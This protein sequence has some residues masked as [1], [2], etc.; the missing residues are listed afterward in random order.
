[1][2]ELPEVRWVVNNLQ[3]E[4]V[5]ASIDAAVVTFEKVIL[6]PATLRGITT[7]QYL[8]DSVTKRKVVSIN[9]RGKYVLI[10]LE[11][12]TTILTHFSF[13]GW[14]VPAWAEKAVPRE[15]LHPVDHE[16]HARVV[17]GTD[18]GLLYLT[19][20][21]GLS[22]T[23]IFKGEAEALKSPMLAEMGPDADTDAGQEAL[24]KAIAKTGRRI[25][26]L[27]MD[28]KV[29]CGVGNYLACESLFRAGVHGAEPAKSLPPEKI[30]SLLAAIKECIHLGET[31]ES[32]AWWAVFQRTKCPQEHPV[33][34]EVWGQR[35]HYVCYAHQP[36][37]VNWKKN[38]LTL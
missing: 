25:R 36:P 7:E 34:R 10:N 18:K 33:T 31:E 35:G 4:L 16:R 30:T 32:K 6:K 9:R 19:D 29:A 12:D 22:K 2:P 11:P 15:F 37:P 5:G 1:V 21:R 13:T 27:I 17:Y 38:S 28:Q 8:I 20:P 23:W 14:Y 24:T 3:K 26:D